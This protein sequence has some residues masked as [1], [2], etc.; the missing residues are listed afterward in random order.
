MNKFE[1]WLMS[2][3]DLIDAFSGIITFGFYRSS[4]GFRFCLMCYRKIAIKKK[5]ERIID[6]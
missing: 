3:I 1:I 5:M 4:F 6:E 2:W